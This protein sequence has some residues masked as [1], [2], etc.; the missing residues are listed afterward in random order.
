[1]TARIQREPQARSL[2]LPARSAAPW[3]I[4]PLVAALAAILL[5]L[6]VPPAW[7]LLQVSVHETL[8]DGSL[9][10]FTTRFYEQLITGRFF[11]SSLWNTL[12]YAFGSAIVAIVFGTVQ[13]LIVER[14]NTPGRKLAFLAA[15]ISLGVPHVL[16]V[17]AWLLLL[18][19]AGPVNEFLASLTG[20]GNAVDVYS[21]AGMVLIEGI[22]FA[23]LSFLLMS[24]VLR[25]TDASFEEAALMSGAGPAR[26]FWIV[27]LRLAFPGLCALTLLIFV[28]AFES[29]ETPALVGLAGNVSVLT[30]MI[31]QSSHRT[32]SPE[33]G[34]AGA[35]SVLLVT[36]VIALLAW[37]NRLSRNAHRYQTITGKG[38]RPRIMD[39]GPWRHA[40]AAILAGLFLIVTVI[41]VAMLI[42][43][44]LQ[45]FYEG[46][47]LESFSRFTTENYSVLFASPLPTR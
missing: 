19:R 29:F 18:G 36:I 7:F 35:Y 4:S 8:P 25:S 28:K 47:S 41:P 37:Q 32:G 45:P 31:F 39:L 14:T 38:F 1:M 20:Y 5:V 2:D 33:Y 43:T 34:E 15:I 24:A 11:L 3:R 21:I 22:G 44:S 23:P 27:T 9:G 10:A 13:A 16:Y 46:V 6:V 17:V 42:F 30:T 26:A 40:T 12:V